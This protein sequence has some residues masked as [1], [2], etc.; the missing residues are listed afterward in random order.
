MQEKC[1][2]TMTFNHLLRHHDNVPQSSPQ[3]RQHFNVLFSLFSRTCLR[4][5]ASLLSC[6]MGELRN[7]VARSHEN[8]KADFS[9]PTLFFQEKKH[10][11]NS[12]FWPMGVTFL[13]PG[14]CCC[15]RPELQ[16]KSRNVQHST[17]LQYC[18]TQH[19]GGPVKYIF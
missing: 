11:V 5:Y 10:V 19:T 3:H 12:A 2:S 18:D 9:D 17:R 13:T 8:R 7:P 15:W 4:D 6:N 1:M 14:L 16:R